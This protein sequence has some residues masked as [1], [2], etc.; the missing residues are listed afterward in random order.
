MELNLN[1]AGGPDP[2]VED[3][4]GGGDVAVLAQPGHVLQE[5]LGA[6]RQLILVGP[7]EG[8]LKFVKCQKVVYDLSVAYLYSAVLPQPRHY[9]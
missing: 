2:G 1:D 3:V 4:L 5:I 9:L 8:R 6:V 7:Q